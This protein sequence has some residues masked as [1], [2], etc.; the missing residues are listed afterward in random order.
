MLEKGFRR[1]HGTGANIIAR[2]RMKIGEHYRSGLVT[3]MTGYAKAW[4]RWFTLI[5]SA[6]MPLSL[7]M[8]ALASIGEGQ[9]VL[10]IGT[11]IGE[12]A[13]TAA[14]TVGPR[15]SVLAIDPDPEMI[16][17]ARER[18]AVEKLWNIEF[19][20]QCA[21]QLLLPPSSVDSVLCRWSLMFVDD[22]GTTL[23]TLRHVLRQGGRLVASTWGPPDRVPALSLAR[24]VIHDHFGMEAPL[25]GRKSAFALS[26]THHLANSFGTAGFTQIVQERISLVFKFRSAEEYVQFRTDC[27]GPLFS[28]VGAVSDAARAQALR[29][30]ATAL[31]G[32]RAPD[33]SFRLENDAYCTAGAVNNA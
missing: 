20:V 24:T 26:D 10:D 7:R 15:G 9:R 1:A 22:L 32:F 29:A 27:T 12:P 2:V 4:E 11:G 33:G 19:A 14:C 30:V 31:E 21:E 16:A 17:I 28:G 8:L 6:A 3:P 18:A 13:M 23:K 5:E 25:Y